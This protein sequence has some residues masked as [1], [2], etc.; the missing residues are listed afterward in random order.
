[1]MAFTALVM[2]VRKGTSTGT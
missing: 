1:M 2:L